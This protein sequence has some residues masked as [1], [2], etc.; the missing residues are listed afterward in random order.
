MSSTISSRNIGFTES[1]QQSEMNPP[2]LFDGSGSSN[3][4]HKKFKRFTSSIDEDRVRCKRCQKPI[5]G[6]IS[7]IEEMDSFCSDCRTENSKGKP[8]KPKFHKATLYQSANNNHSGHFIQ[9][10]IGTRNEPKEIECQYQPLV[11]QMHN[12]CLN[13][14]QVH[15]L[16]SIHFIFS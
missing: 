10:I 3:Y 7:C 4:L 2:I 8:Y 13:V 6:Q 15:I 12:F 16:I 5:N 1:S 11:S 14:N 9:D